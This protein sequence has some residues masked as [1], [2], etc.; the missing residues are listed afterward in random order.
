[1]DERIARLKTPEECD[2]LV[3]NVQNRL[4]DLAQAADE[5]S[6]SAPQLTVLRV[7]WREKR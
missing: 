1:M 7:M 3:I 2:Q 5:Q 6:N 4:P